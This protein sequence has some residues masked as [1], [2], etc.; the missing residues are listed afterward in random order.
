MKIMNNPLKTFEK[1]ANENKV[2]IF[3]SQLL[4][5][6]PDYIVPVEKKGCKLLRAFTSSNEIF[7]N[8]IRYIQF[9]QNTN[10]DIKGKKIVVVDDATRYTSSLYD[11]RRQFEEAGAIVSTHSF[12]GQEHLA[13]TDSIQ[14]DVQANIFQ[15]LS[16]STYREY[17]LQ[18]SKFLSKH[19]N[20]F[21]IDHFVVRFNLTND[22]FEKMLNLLDHVGE[23]EYANDVYTPTFIEKVTLY[24]CGFETAEQYFNSN[25]SRSVLQKIRLTYNK[26][27]STV[28][29]VPL[30]FPVWNSNLEKD[31]RSMFARVPFFLPYDITDSVID[32]GLYMNICFAFHVVLLKEFLN[33]IAAIGEN[34]EFYIELQDLSAYVGEDRTVSVNDSVCNFLQNETVAKTGEKRSIISVEHKTK[35]AFLSVKSIMKTLRDGYNK[36]VKDEDTAVG[37]HYCLSYDELFA[38]YTGRANL[39][40][41]IDIL[42]DRGT[43][44][45]R[46][47]SENG[48]F[49]RACR[50]GEVESDHIEKKTELLLPIVINSCGTQKGDFFRITATYLNKVLANLAHDYPQEDF[51]FHNL[52]TK[53]YLYGPMT[54][55]QDKLNDEEENSIY[56]IEKISKYCQYDKKAKE[57]LAISKDHPKL[58]SEIEQN[59]SL[60]DDVP[61]TDIL[62]YLDFLKCIHVEFGKAD[63]LNMLV[64]C[65]NQDIYYRH[66]HFNIKKAL[67][68]IQTSLYITSNNS[69]KED[70]LREAA[71]SVKSAQTKLKYEPNKDFGILQSKIGS[72]MIYHEAYSKIHNSRKPFS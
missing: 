19:E 29:I 43:L 21:D 36:R 51:D 54:Y 2:K 26:Q 35:D 32:D 7:Q 66:V 70:F 27:S 55:A 6:N 17:I 15:F 60:T 62:L 31:K 56:K 28:T 16:E 3:L 50:S 5:E 67:Q 11:Y 44:V 72:K 65:R 68:D 34:S 13:L 1:Y 38:R 20:S 52:Y 71:K 49:F 53:P 47:I 12:V 25:V 9:F 37:V 24:N 4:D 57:F 42:C 40:K 58:S 63:V 39:T 14:Y 45:T 18:Q 10:V 59:F 33:S 23:I 30:S 61:F 46:N 48:V 64:I 41:W 8:K 69:I 22:G